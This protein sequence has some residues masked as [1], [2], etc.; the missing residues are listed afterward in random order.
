MVSWPFL[1]VRVSFY[2]FI[3][4]CKVGMFRKIRILGFVIPFLYV[5]IHIRFFEN[6]SHLPVYNFFL[7][8]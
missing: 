4:D 5:R 7:K 1:A 3:P 2:F 6:R 8:K